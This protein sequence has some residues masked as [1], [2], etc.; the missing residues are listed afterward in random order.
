V[1]IYLGEGQILEAPES[2]SVVRIASMRW[3]GFIGGARP[4]A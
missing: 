4:S 3:G 2:G 1:A